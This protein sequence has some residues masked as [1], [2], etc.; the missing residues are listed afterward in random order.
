MPS[1]FQPKEIG[2]NYV[3]GVWR[4]DFQVQS[5]RRFRLVR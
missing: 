1:N 5:V 4:D 3:L 2:R